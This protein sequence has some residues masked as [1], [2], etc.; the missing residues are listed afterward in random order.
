M[1]WI[2][3][4]LSVVIAIATKWYWEK[5][6]SKDNL[7]IQ[8]KRDLSNNLC[9]DTDDVGEV[10]VILFF[11]AMLIFVPAINLISPFWSLVLIVWKQVSIRI[12]GEAKEKTAKLLMKVLYNKSCKDLEK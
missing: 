12:S 9:K 6:G 3:Y 7:Y 5:N 1:T 10:V 4:I 2:V 11:Y 8:I